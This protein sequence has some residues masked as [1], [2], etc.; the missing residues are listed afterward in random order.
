M[1]IRCRVKVKQMTRQEIHPKATRG[2]ALRSRGLA[3]PVVIGFGRPLD[4]ELDLLLP[5]FPFM[6][7]VVGGA[8]G[9]GDPFTGNVDFKAPPLFEGV[10]KAPKL[11]DEL[12]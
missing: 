8:N 7:N 10:R 9:D 1:V 4:L 5:C 6:L 2:S 11:L 3:L 12:R